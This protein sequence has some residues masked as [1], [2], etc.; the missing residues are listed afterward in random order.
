M[1]G[2]KFRVVTNFHEDSANFYKNKKTAWVIP[3]RFFVYSNY[4][5]LLA[6]PL[7]LEL[8]A[9]YTQIFNGFQW[10]FQ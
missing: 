3:K 5:N 7:N 4:V 9:I 8:P 2:L 10:H 6:R 1:S